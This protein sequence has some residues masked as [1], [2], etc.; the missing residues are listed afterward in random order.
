[1]MI[2]WE[3]RFL[4]IPF[5]T[6]NDTTGTNLCTSKKTQKAL[7]EWVIKEQRPCLKT[8]DNVLQSLTE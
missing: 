1:M 2:F 5:L 6:P 4:V 7:T 3:V 8:I